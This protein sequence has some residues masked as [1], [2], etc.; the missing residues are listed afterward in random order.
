MSNAFVNSVKPKG[1]SVKFQSVGAEITMQI[2]GVSEQ[3]ATTYNL[4]GP[5]E[6]KFF[7]SGDKIMD[8][9]V[10]GLDVNAESEE[11]A[12]VVLFVDK[13]AMR[14]AIGK[15]LIA[16]DAGEPLPGGTL[17]IKFTGFGV[18]KNSANPPKA[19]EAEYWAPQ[20]AAGSWGGEG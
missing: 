13:L 3:Q 10:S 19:F 4:N 17:R 1:K 16:K 20:A 5:G 9:V 15:A 7:P 2:T 11:E 14:Q 6:P 12:A 18:G 8:Q